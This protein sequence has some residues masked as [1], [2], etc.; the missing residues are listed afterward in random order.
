M[1][2]QRPQS[3]QFGDLTMRRDAG[4][5]RVWR[6]FAAS[7]EMIAGTR[8]ECLAYVERVAPSA[9]RSAWAAAE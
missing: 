2:P 8:E 6:V 1:R 5:S 7:V 9:L 4:A 3:Y